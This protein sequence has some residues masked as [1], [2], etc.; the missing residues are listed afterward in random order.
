MYIILLI[1]LGNL[2]LILGFNQEEQ[3]TVF[4]KENRLWI[5]YK[6]SPKNEWF[7]TTVETT[8]AMEEFHHSKISKF[9]SSF[10]C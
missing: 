8:F 4:H 3:G 10:I 7:Y 5:S 2:S 9:V 6:I 1:S